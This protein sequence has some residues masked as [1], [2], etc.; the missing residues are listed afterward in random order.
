M[1]VWS[2][3]AATNGAAAGELRLPHGF[4]PAEAPLLQSAGHRDARGSVKG[5][6]CAGAVVAALRE[7]AGDGVVLAVD[8]DGTVECKQR[9]AGDAIS[10]SVVELSG[11]WI[12]P[13]AG[14]P[15]AP[16]RQ[17]ALA[18]VLLGL[19]PEGAPLV[20]TPVD[21]AATVWFT[22]PALTPE[23][24]PDLPGPSERA[25]HAFSEW[26]SEWIPR[27]TAMAGALPELEGG[28]LEIA[29]PADKAK[30]GTL[31]FDVPK[32]VAARWFAGDLGD[33]VL[34]QGMTIGWSPDP[35]KV[36]F[37]RLQVDVEAGTPRERVTPEARTI[38]V[39][40]GDLEG[41]EDEPK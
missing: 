33:D 19:L 31:R 4:K 41:L 10:A 16:D 1:F 18:K 9:K 12:V 34:V 29:W 32:G 38:D 14:A 20:L 22:W 2:F 13:G 36:P 40:P 24:L 26:V 30:N 28:R 35:R 37:E 11:W 7:L 5:D 17:L 6:D 15:V 27:W 25:A 3:L 21:G 23:S 8:G 39:K